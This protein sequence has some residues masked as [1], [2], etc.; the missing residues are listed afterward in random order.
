MNLAEAAGHRPPLLSLVSRSWLA[1]F[2]SHRPGNRQSTANP[3]IAAAR[4]CSETEV[5]LSLWPRRGSALLAGILL[6]AGSYAEAQ[7]FGR[8]G[9]RGLDQ[10]GASLP[11][12]AIELVGQS[13]ELS[14]TTDAAGKYRFES[15]PA[16]PASL[17]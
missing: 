10:T 9:G 17:T 2:D 11:G 16:G 13:R 15:V 4:R 1:V 8:V 14:A 6:L 3:N 5:P 7:P 12:V